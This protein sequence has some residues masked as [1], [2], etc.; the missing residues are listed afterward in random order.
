M[1]T[2]HLTCE[3]TFARLVAVRNSRCLKLNELEVVCDY[4]RCVARKLR[5]YA[6]NL[7]NFD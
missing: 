6:S 3:F 5:V 1:C 2:S 7:Y 4:L